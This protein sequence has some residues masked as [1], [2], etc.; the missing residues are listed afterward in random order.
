MTA[1]AL[2]SRVGWAPARKERTNKICRLLTYLRH[3]PTYKQPPGSTRSSNLLN[4]DVSPNVS[5][6]IQFFSDFSMTAV[7]FPDI[8]RFSRQVLVALVCAT[9]ITEALYQQND[10]TMQVACL[11]ILL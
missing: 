6:A 2:E 9:E 1:Y 11:N 4:S 8:S 7:K 3:L 5:L 10:G